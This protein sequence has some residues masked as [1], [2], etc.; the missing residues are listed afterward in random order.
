MQNLSN[1]PLQPSQPIQHSSSLG[2]NPVF[3]GFKNFLERNLPGGSSRWVLENLP[4]DR[5]GSNFDRGP[6]WH[7]NYVQPNDQA[8]IEAIFTQY[9][10]G[11]SSR[12]AVTERRSIIEQYT[13]RFGCAT[14][15]SRDIIAQLDATL[16]QLPPTTSSSSPQFSFPS[17]TP[18]SSHYITTAPEPQPPSFMT[19]NNLPFPSF[20]PQSTFLPSPPPQDS[21]PV[22]SQ[23]PMFPPFPLQSQLS[24]LPPTPLL[25]QISWTASNAFPSVSPMPNPFLQPEPQLPPSQQQQYQFIPNLQP[26]LPLVESSIIPPQTQ[27]QPFQLFPSQMPSFL[28]QQPQ[29]T[30]PSVQSSIIPL[31]TPQQPIQ[32]SPSQSLFIPSPT[33]SYPSPQQP[34]SP[35]QLQL[36][37]E[38][39]PFQMPFFLQQPQ[40]QQQFQPTLPSVQAF[41]PMQ[42]PSST[43]QPQAS[44]LQYSFIP[45]EQPNVQLQQPLTV[46]TAQPQSPTPSVQS[47]QPLP[48]PVMN[49]LPTHAILQHNPQQWLSTFASQQNYTQKKDMRVNILRQTQEAWSAVPPNEVQA[50]LQ[51]TTLYETETGRTQRMSQLGSG[52]P[53]Q[54]Q[55][56]I[57]P[58]VLSEQPR[59]PTVF[60]VEVQDSFEAGRAL[61]VLDPTLNPVVLNMANATEGGGGAE[62]GAA[63]QE[64]SLCRRSNLLQA[65]RYDARTG[66]V[67][68]GTPRGY[69]I[70]AHGAIYTNNV[71]VFRKNEQEGCELIPPYRMAVISSAAI[72]RTQQSMTDEQYCTET[73]QR[74]IAQLRIACA[75]GH[76]SIVLG[77]F[78]C[79]AFSGGNPD[80]PAMVADLYRQVL[81]SDEFRGVF[82]VVR[83]AIIE[84]RNA[85]LGGNVAPFEN[86]FLPPDV[87]QQRQT[88][89]N[90]PLSS[91]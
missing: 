31:P 33:T 81:N 77:A 2:S 45:S 10:R 9:R 42:P 76:R 8:F 65:L 22:L 39:S 23:T 52:I 86:A 74:I 27:Q 30:L 83:F 73:R 40:E 41:F 35:V 49:F 87:A 44:Q 12:E 34:Q 15:R 20:T 71:F 64:E 59:Y 90:P 91:T 21:Q 13:Q 89:R 72:N 47:S 68:N 69:N 80:V 53:P 17:V 60:Q 48:P 85:P 50:M 63:A 19:S 82:A 46:S 14:S 51:S 61:Q 75:Q 43:Q 79:G 6:N 37:I 84:D 28:Q 3:A 70:P 26:T 62:H 66:Q 38:P 11:N 29:P 7:D 36:P 58:P 24:Q 56:R 4:L 67:A 32:Q 5:L 16:Q 18:L 54:P 25:N 88:A 55:Q 57:I 1:I 78:G